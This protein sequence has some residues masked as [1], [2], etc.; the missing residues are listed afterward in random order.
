M[1]PV[2]S[3]SLT[4]DGKLGLSGSGDKT[5]RLWDLETG[6]CLNTTEGFGDWVWSVNL[7]P[8]GYYGISGQAEGPLRLFRF[9][10]DLEFE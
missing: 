1:L 10:F 5:V 9:I 7:T 8:D 6:R 2:T 3:V 4:M